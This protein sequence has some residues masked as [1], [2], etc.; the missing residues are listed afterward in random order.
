MDLRRT[1]FLRFLA[2]FAIL[3]FHFGQECPSLRWGQPLWAIANSATSFFYLLS[4]FILTCVYSARSQWTAGGFYRARAARILPLYVLA[5]LPAGLGLWWHGGVSG[6]ELVLVLLLL[7]A[8]VPGHSLSIVNAPAWSLSVEAFFYLT[9]PFTQKL[10]TRLTAPRRLLAAMAML[11]LAGQYLHWQAMQPFLAGGGS[12]WLWDASHHHPL[13]HLATF[14]IGAVGGRFHLL[15]GAACRRAAPW[16]VLAAV[17]GLV[18][19]AYWSPRWLMYH[20]NGLLAPLFLLLVLGVTW[21]AGPWF[22]VLASRPLQLLGEI[23]Y[24]IYILQMPAHLLFCVGIADLGW[25]PSPEASFWTF[26][27]VLCLLSWVS[28]RFV[29]TPLRRWISGPAPAARA[30]R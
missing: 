11:W 26:S 6:V 12:K 21:G 22:D 18:G 15:H 20:H 27:A 24:G 25:T 3:V 19:V 17:G 4:G 5:T 14:L 28:W 13:G 7:Q 30:P 9:F 23:S 1:T 29:E 10:V 2:A 16:L 8:W